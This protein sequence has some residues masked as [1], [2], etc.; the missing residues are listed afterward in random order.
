MDQNFKRTYHDLKHLA[1]FSCL[2]TLIE[3]LQIYLNIYIYIECHIYICV[4]V[5][6]CVCM[7]MY[8][9]MHI[10]I[11]L[12]GVKLHLNAIHIGDRYCFM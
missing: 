3:T 1:I 10:Y 12:H 6:V 4:C 5:C 9:C 11:M 7:C 2:K 8:V